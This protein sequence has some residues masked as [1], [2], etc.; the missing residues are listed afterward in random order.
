MDGCFANSIFYNYAYTYTFVVNI[1]IF[2]PWVDMNMNA[3]FN[4]TDHNNQLFIYQ[5]SAAWPLCWSPMWSAL[6]NTLS[7]TSHISA[8]DRQLMC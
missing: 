7:H 3:N 2:P 4:S 8:E 5:F 1:Q 6:A